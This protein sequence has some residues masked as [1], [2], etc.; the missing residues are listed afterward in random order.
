MNPKNIKKSNIDKIRESKE[1][2][3]AVNKD[4]DDISKRI[5]KDAVDQIKNRYMHSFDLHMSGR[6]TD[7]QLEEERIRTNKALAKFHS[8]YRY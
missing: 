3:N 7:K 4:L 5:D 1:W 6:I 2:E 8:D